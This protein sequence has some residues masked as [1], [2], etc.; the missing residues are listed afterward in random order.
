MLSQ[1]RTFLFPGQQ[2]AIKKQ[3]V[4]C[5]AGAL[6]TVGGVGEERAAEK[7]RRN[8]WHPKTEEMMPTWLRMGPYQQPGSE[9]EKGGGW[10]PG[11]NVFFQV[12]WEENSLNSPKCHGWGGRHFTTGEF[13][14]EQVQME[15]L[16][17]AFH[18]PFMRTPAC[19]CF[20]A[21]NVPAP[22]LGSFRDLSHFDLLTIVPVIFLAVA[23]PGHG[24]CFNSQ[25]HFW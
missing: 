20:P 4:S 15:Q 14:K 9:D 13:F 18:L 2:W 16:R 21:C 11:D 22:K 19:Y 12:N 5:L 17:A 8:I 23:L 7:K 10:S 1:N 6:R 3:W 24:N 25:V